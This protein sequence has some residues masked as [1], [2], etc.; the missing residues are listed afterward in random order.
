[1]SS[2]CLDCLQDITLLVSSVND[3]SQNTHFE[4]ITLGGFPSEDGLCD[5]MLS[6]ACELV[7]SGNNTKEWKET[8]S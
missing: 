4:I 7:P 5:Y 2:F 6:S 3:K 8:I 1:M